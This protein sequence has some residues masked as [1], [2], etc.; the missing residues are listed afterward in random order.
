MHYPW[1]K[2]TLLEDELS[3]LGNEWS[4]FRIQQPVNLAL[5]ALY[6]WDMYSLGSE[7]FLLID[8]QMSGEGRKTLEGLEELSKIKWYV[9]SEGRP[10]FIGH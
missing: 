3:G 1:N 4:T 9:E 6:R 8:V 5:G 2:S 7:I 10:T